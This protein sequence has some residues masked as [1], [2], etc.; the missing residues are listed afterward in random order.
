M[1][2]SLDTNKMYLQNRLN[3]TTSR[4]IDYADKTVDEIITEEAK[5]GNTEGIEYKREL[6]GN[7]DELI[8]S[9]K[10]DDPTNKFNIIKE[11]SPEQQ[12]EV[13][14]MLEA[15]ALVLG[16]NFFTQDKLLKM[17][18]KVPSLEAVNVVL[19][20]FTL[21]QIVSMIPLDQLEKFFK[22][23]DVEQKQVVKQLK[24]MPQEMLIQMAESMTGQASDVNDAMSL[25]ATISALPE[26]EYKETMSTMD[27]AIQ[28]QV[29]FQM[30]DN[31]PRIL[32]LFDSSAFA[33]MI[34][35]LQ[36]P[37]MVKSLIGLDI[38]SLQVMTQELPPDLFSIVAS[39]VDTKI[40]AT[41]LM[42]DCKD[43]LTKLGAK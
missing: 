38:E 6:F 5:N 8:G 10:L 29:V 34:Q 11:F 35:K 23:D 7:R 31:D 37:D 1:T 33:G 25:I 21:E 15:E 36:K 2:V 26:K 20:V 27:P 4:M 28:M 13:L 42:E 12:S 41:Y 22:S 32:A 43:F 17:F 16:L 40:F 14:P 39:Q 30:A 19:G 3:I 18:E 9:F 24:Q